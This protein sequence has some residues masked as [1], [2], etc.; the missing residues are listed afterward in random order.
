MPQIYEP[1]GKAREYSPLALNYIKGCDHGCIYCYVPPMMSRFNSNYIHRNVDTRIDFKSI[2]ASA[3]KMHGCNK[4]IL[5]SFTTDPYSKQ[6]IQ[7]T[8]RVLEIL[9]YYKHKVAILTKG[10]S[11]CLKDIEIFKQFGNRIKVGASLT[12]DNEKDTKIWEPGSAMPHDRIYALKLLS[13]NGIKTWVSF[14]PTI[15][16][17]Q[18]L[19]LIEQVSEF[20]DHI[21]IGK[22]N[23]Y[24][25]I[26]KSINWAKFIDD[27]VNICRK[28]NILFYIKKDLVE[29]N[30][31]TKLF[32]NEL[33]Q[34]YLCL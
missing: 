31:N 27:A 29:Y 28:N 17:E 7:E 25:G 21:K 18:T 2:T 30:V 1:K 26:D 32:D 22:L 14:E 6:V 20:I 12:F 4:Q 33:N 3:K 10:G 15:I 34:D 8:R 9:N 13:K 16:P 24:K 19:N 5:L 23:N 11:R